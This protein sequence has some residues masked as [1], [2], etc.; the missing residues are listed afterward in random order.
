MRIVRATIALSLALAILVLEWVWRH[1]TYEDLEQRDGKC[2]VVGE[3]VN[4]GRVP[5]VPCQEE[6]ART[7]RAVV[8]PNGDCPDGFSLKD[9]HTRA[10]ALGS[11]PLDL[12]HDTVVD[13]EPMP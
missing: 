2:V 6:G 9:F 10:L 1:R 8:G 5:V 13:T 11:L 12:L 3:T 4:N 7:V